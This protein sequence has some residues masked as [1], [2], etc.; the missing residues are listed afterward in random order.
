MAGDNAN[1]TARHIKIEEATLTDRLVGTRVPVGGQEPLPI[2]DGIICPHYVDCY[3]PKK[4]MPVCY[5]DGNI[6][7]YHSCSHYPKE[8]YEGEK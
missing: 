3:H 2:P 4:A 1:R 6:H 8:R 5:L 7:S